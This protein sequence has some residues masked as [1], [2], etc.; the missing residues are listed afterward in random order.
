MFKFLRKDDLLV[1]DNCEIFLFV[2]KGSFGS[3]KAIDLEN[4]D[5]FLIG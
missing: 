5:W 1:T 4:S 3:F 2:D